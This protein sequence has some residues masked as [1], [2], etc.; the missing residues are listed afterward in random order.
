MY[1]PNSFREQD[2]T[3]LH[4]FIGEFGF[5]TV[6]SFTSSLHVSHL[7][8]VLVADRGARGTLIGHMAKANEHWKHFDGERV[9]T[10]IFH[11]PH[12]YIS[13]S[14]YEVRPAVP[15]WNYAV[16]HAT[17]RPRLIDGKDELGRAIDR[18]LAHFEPELLEPQ[19]DARLSDADRE[20]LLDHI[21]GFEMEIDTLVG[22]YKLG[23]NRTPQDQKGIMTGLATRP[24]AEAQALLAFIRARK[25][26]G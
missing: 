16:V 8:L 22:K 23:Q 10:C 13:P 24:N 21:V 9:A 7:P 11:G 18:M 3:E 25:T 12:A 6:V 20:N 19:S 4:R 1:V 5:S 2:T 15:T 17:G 14:W 26:R